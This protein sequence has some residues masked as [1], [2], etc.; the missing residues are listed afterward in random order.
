[1][2]NNAILTLFLFSCFFTQVKGD[3]L[4]SILIVL[5]QTIKNNTVYIAAK[6]QRIAAIKQMLNVADIT[7]QQEYDINKKLYQEYK[8]FVSDSAIVYA[9]KNVLIAEELKNDNW[10]YE[11]KL[12]LSML[13]SVSGMYLEALD[14]QKSISVDRLPDRLKIYYYEA[15]KELADFYSFNSEY[16]QK[17]T[18]YRDSI[19]LLRDPESSFYKKL[20]AEKLHSSGNYLQAREIFVSLFKASEKESHW[21]GGLAYCIGATYKT[22]GNYEMQKKYFAISAISDLKNAVKQNVS[23]RELSVAFNETRDVER[24]YRYIQQS[25]ED[26]VFSNAYFRRMEVADYLPVVEKLYQQKIQMQNRNLTTMLI[27]IGVISLFLIVVIWYVCK[28]KNKLSA[29]RKSLSEVN[30]SLNELNVKVVGINKELSESNHVKEE[31]VG[32]YMDQSSF[33]LEKLEQYRRS[34]NRIASN[35]N[36]EELFRMLKSHQFL[37]DEIRDFYTNFDKSFLELFPDFVECFNALLEKDG[38]IVPKPKEL[39]N[40]ELRIFALIRLGITDSAKIATFLR[41]PA[42]TIYT[43]R[44][45][46]RKRAL[47]EKEEFEALVMQ[48][49]MIDNE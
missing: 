33:Y 35:G 31:Y 14:I 18:L 11:S 15:C 47:Y 16:H 10:L 32:R 46:I 44:T 28:Q 38:R 12:N 42:S 13:C 36:M 7:S 45:K 20:Y 27:I 5:D 24:A 39:L 49:G 4:D 26:A 41:S 3:D 25:M 19:L 30:E 37:E 6:Q 8:T 2:K 21:Y 43:Y 1:M 9:K 29:A 17:H 40:T 34:L 22:E 23:L 48:I